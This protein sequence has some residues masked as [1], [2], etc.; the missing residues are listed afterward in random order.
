MPTSSSAIW[1]QGGILK[2]H[3]PRL[4][5]EPAYLTHI[6][7]FFLLL[8][9][10]IL[11][12]RPPQNLVALNGSYVHYIFWHCGPRNQGLLGNSFA[13]CSD[14]NYVYS[15]INYHYPLVFTLWLSWSERSK[16]ILLPAW[17]LGEGSCKVS[18]L[19]P[20]T[21][22]AL[23]IYHTVTLHWKRK[24]SKGCHCHVVWG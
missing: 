24:I 18:C 15:D 20:F 12:Q 21:S 2:M 4:N 17:H 11:T 22:E 16:A 7:L 3:W 9:M 8:L 13:P 23:H 6:C 19:Y 1:S 14:T 5:E 10:S